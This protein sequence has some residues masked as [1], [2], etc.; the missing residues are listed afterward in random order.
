MNSPNVSTPASLPEFPITPESFWTEFAKVLRQR[1]SPE[2]EQ[3]YDDRLTWTAFITELLKELAPVF[4]CHS[5]CEYWP[6]VDVSYFDRRTDNNWMEW[7]REAAIEHENN[8]GW[9]EEICKLLEINAGLKVLIA[10]A[11]D[12]RTISDALDRLPAIHQSRKYV[13]SR[14]NWLF[15]FGPMGGEVE[16][17]LAFKF[18]GRAIT[19]ITGDLRITTAGGSEPMV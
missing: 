2:V 10:Y 11:S 1:W 5:D 15:I 8:Q 9:T 18:D 17:F 3:W 16:D 14:C 19:E 6:R 7:S 4:H 13:T 12:R